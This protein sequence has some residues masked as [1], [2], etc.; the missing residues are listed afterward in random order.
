MQSCLEESISSCPKGQ[1]GWYKFCS[2]DDYA[3]CLL[4]DIY[5][6]NDLLGEG[7]NYISN[8]V[9]INDDNKKE[10]EELFDIARDRA[11]RES[12]E[13]EPKNFWFIDND[14]DEQYR[15]LSDLKSHVYCM[16]TDDIVKLNGM[17]AVHYKNGE[18][19]STVEITVKKLRPFFGKVEKNNNL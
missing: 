11:Y 13:E 15:T 7:I 17:T 4:Q 2:F 1:R 19:V 5:N 6:D 12:A 8:K 16:C 10:I 18:T 3:D 14:N 9:V